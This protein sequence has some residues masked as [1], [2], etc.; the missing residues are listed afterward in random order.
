MNEIEM[1]TKADEDSRDASTEFNEK[2]ELLSTQTVA[3]H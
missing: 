3:A 1:K 2:E